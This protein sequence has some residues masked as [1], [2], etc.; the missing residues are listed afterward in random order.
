MLLL[1]MVLYHSDS[2][3]TNTWTQDESFPTGG[4][5]R[6]VLLSI[7]RGMREVALG[8]EQCLTGM[9]S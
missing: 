8:T 1:A 5:L 6:G 3:G 9:S 4:V 7:S 2:K